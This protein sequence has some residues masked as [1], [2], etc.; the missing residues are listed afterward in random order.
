[1]ERECKRKEKRKEK[2]H[3]KKRRDGEYIKFILLCALKGIN[4]FFFM[5]LD[6]CISSMSYH[7]IV[8]NLIW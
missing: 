1:L 6:L 5:L 3:N 2:K 4:L 8:D 7:V